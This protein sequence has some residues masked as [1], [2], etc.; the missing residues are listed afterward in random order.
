MDCAGQ[1]YLRRLVSVVALSCEDVLED[2]D[3]VVALSCEDVLEDVDFDLDTKD[4]NFFQWAPM[5]MPVRNIGTI[6]LNSSLES[7]ISIGR[8]SC[9]CCV[10]KSCITNCNKSNKSKKFGARSECQQIWQV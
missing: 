5:R 6:V 9:G 10:Y 4:N 8:Y 2:V 1:K 3:F 7:M